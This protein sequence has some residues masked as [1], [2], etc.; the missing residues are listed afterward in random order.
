LKLASEELIEYHYVKQAT[1][2][3]FQMGTVESLAT[4]YRAVMFGGVV[5]K[6][7]SLAHKKLTVTVPKRV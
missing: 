2:M 3:L 4:Q 1:P 5:F 7:P 6:F